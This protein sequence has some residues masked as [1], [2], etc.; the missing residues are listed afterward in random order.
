MS[1]QIDEATREFYSVPDILDYAYR[2]EAGQN[3]PQMMTELMSIGTNPTDL[4]S[5]EMIADGI[6]IKNRAMRNLDTLQRHVISSCYRR[7]Y[8]SKLQS[9]HEYDISGLV[10]F[11]LH[12]KP[13]Y[14]NKHFVADVIRDWSYNGRAHHDDLIKFWSENM[15]VPKSTV[16]RWVNG[17]NSI[18]TLITEWK[19]LAEHKLE[20][21]FVDLIL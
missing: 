13:K 5:L 17:G 12:D 14:K 1:A 9:Q 18:K 3:T 20:A 11:I 6:M 16:Q 2:M 10:M 19:Q 15:G 4:D 21:V 8:D 7:P